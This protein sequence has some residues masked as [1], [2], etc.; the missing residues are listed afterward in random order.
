MR[1]M[2]SLAMLVGLIALVVIPAV[3]QVSPLRVEDVVA[4]HSFSEFTPITFSPDG[5]AVVYA[6][7]DNRKR[8]AFSPDDY[9]RTGVSFIGL[10][11]DIFVVQITTGEV[12]NLTRGDNNW[13]PSL[14][15]DGRYLAFLSDR[16]GSGQA[17]LWIVEMATGKMRKASEV[18][19]RTN[20]IQWL[21]N[22]REV[23]LI[24]ITPHKRKRLVVRGAWCVETAL[25][26]RHAPCN[27]YFFAGSFFSS[28]ST[29]FPGFRSLPARPGYSGP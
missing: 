23:L 16:D 2:E 1:A 28:S 7:K 5:K 13:D 22:S 19:V 3:A 24:D 29:V 14:S 25:P 20:E 15:P 12:T 18:I 27:S 21:P 10:G 26:S 9:P 8:T 17:K 11:A 6:A 4:T